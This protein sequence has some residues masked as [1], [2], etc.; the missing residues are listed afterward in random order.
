MY[1]IVRYVVLTRIHVKKKNTMQTGSYLRM[2]TKWLNAWLEGKGIEKLC[3]GRARSPMWL[4]ASRQTAQNST[5]NRQK[6]LFFTVN[7]QKCGRKVST[8]FKSP[9]FSRSS[10]TFGSWRISKL[11]KLFPVLKHNLSRHYK[12]IHLTYI[13]KSDYNSQCL[14]VQKLICT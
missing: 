13:W 8:D 9:Y 5:V 14:F 1:L 11:E 10:R 2:L 3:M 12:T 7:R 4:T 6:S